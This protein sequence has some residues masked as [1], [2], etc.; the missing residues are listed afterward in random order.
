MA[1]IGT[2]EKQFVAAHIYAWPE[3][4]QIKK[5]FLIVTTP[6]R[7]LIDQLLGDKYLLVVHYPLCTCSRGKEIS[8]VAERVRRSVRSEQSGCWF[9]YL[10]LIYLILLPLSFET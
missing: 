10:N 4:A 5:P 1:G 7:Q 3:L 2:I 8:C 9:I 6:S